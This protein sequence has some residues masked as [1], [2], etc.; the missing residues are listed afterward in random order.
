MK[1]GYLKFVRWSEDDKVFI[2]YCPDLF[3]GGA[4]HGK[5]EN[6]VYAE[7]CRLVEADIAQRRRSRLPLPPSATIVALPVAA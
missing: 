3:V 5:N 4:C 6:K 2:G 7:L 1:T